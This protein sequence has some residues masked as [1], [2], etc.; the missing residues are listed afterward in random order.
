MILINFT[1]DC[2]DIF[3]P[4]TVRRVLNVYTDD[5]QD[6]YVSCL[7]SGAS[8]LFNLMIISILFILSVMRTILMNYPHDDQDFIF[9]D[10]YQEHTDCIS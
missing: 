4:G 6:L 1:D 5:V 7:L 2:Q 8:W 3:N 10:F 9:P